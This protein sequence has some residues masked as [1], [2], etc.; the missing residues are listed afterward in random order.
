[1]EQNIDAPVLKCN[2]IAGNVYVFCIEKL[3][4]DSSISKYVS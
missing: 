1:V 4:L 3:R 2:A